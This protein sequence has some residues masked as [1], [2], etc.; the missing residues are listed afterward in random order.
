LN[1]P[2]PHA[3]GPGTAVFPFTALGLL[4]Y[5]DHARVRVQRSPDAYVTINYLARLGESKI[6]PP[7]VRF[8]IAH[9]ADDRVLQPV[10]GFHSAGRRTGAGRHCEVR[11][12][13][14][15]DNLSESAVLALLGAACHLGCWAAGGSERTHRDE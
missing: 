8:S 1:R 11:Y 7:R 4:Y 14:S 15:L 6:R 2:A 3:Q 13:V 9:S 5:D 10:E 12:D